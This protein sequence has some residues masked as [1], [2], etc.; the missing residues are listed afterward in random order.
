MTAVG[1]EADESIEIERLAQALLQAPM[2]E[3]DPPTAPGAFS[4]PVRWVVTFFIAYH[5]LLL[6]VYNT[7]ATGLTRGLHYTFDRY[8]QMRSYMAA[9][10]NV[11][12]WA[13]FA[14]DPARVNTFVRVLLQDDTGE[15][16]DLAHDI[17]GRRR[18]PYLFYDRLAKINRR[19]V[20]DSRYLEP[21]AA[22]V[23]RDW[24]RA[25]DGQPA[26]AVRLIEAAT[27]IPPPELAFHEMG[28][29]PERLPLLV[30]QAFTIECQALA[31]AQ[32][33]D[34]IRQRY[35]LPPAAADTIRRAGQYT[36][37]TDKR[38]LGGSEL[39]PATARDRAPQA[40][41]RI[42]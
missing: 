14:P 7:P 11:Q 15:V 42:E 38:R 19:L 3:E 17:Y 30:G 26:R 35:G 41:G 40:E 10:G 27:R 20:E 9:T 23:C 24:E 36:W 2:P 21:Y 8:L 4:R 32:L 13:L 25:G 16:R 29:D 12:S 1:R 28:Y 33:P 18:H 39:A 31:Y 34:R 22:W 37:W 5:A 6:L